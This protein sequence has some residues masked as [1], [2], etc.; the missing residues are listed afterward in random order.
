MELAP[1]AIHATIQ[2]LGEPK[3]DQLPKSAHPCLNRVYA[4]RKDGLSESATRASTRLNFP[5]GSAN[6]LSASGLFRSH[7]CVH[8][9]ASSARFA[10]ASWKERSCSGVMMISLGIGF[11]GGEYFFIGF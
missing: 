7:S 9:N 6:F 11:S 4:P 8:L 5:N 2:S 3:R 10:S 1:T